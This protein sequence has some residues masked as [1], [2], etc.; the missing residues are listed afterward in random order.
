VGLSSDCDDRCIQPSLLLR[1]CTYQ[2]SSYP[3]K[4][5]AFYVAERYDK[6]VKEGVTTKKIEI[7]GPG[8]FSCKEIEPERKAHQISRIY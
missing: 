7:M 8:E 2:V 6:L 1:I 4:G 5:T 3:M